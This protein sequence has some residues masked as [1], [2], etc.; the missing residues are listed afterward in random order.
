MTTVHD[1]QSITALAVK[2][3]RS[4]AAKR[5]AKRLKALAGKRAALTTQIKEINRK[6]DESVDADAIGR[7]V[8]LELVASQ[9]SG[10]ASSITQAFELLAERYQPA[11]E[12]AEPSGPSEVVEPAGN[13]EVLADQ[14]VDDET[15]ETDGGSGDDAEAGDLVAEAAET[16]GVE[17]EKPAIGLPGMFRPSFG[18]FKS[19]V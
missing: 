2:H 19:G 1:S 17:V 12:S 6:I 7:E 11:N 16:D 15:A 10:Q 5:Y 18:Q 13:E 8:L 9:T 4:Q 3:A 14:D